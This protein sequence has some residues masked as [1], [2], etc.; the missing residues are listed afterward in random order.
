[1]SN[2]PHIFNRTRVRAHRDRAAARFAEYD[3]LFRE[4]TLR[5]DERLD[6]FNKSFPVAL[7]LGAH[8]GLLGEMLSDRKTET[9]IYAD[10]SERMLHQAGSGVVCDEEL[11][12]FADNS[13]DLVISACSLHWVN[14]LPG[15]FIQIRKALKPG[16]LFLAILPGGE[17]LKELRQS[18]EQAEIGLTSGVSPRVSPFVDARDAAG[19]LQ[20]AGFQ[21]PVADSDVIDVEYEHPLKLMEDLRGMGEC[22]A[23]EASRKNFT[24]RKLIQRACEQYATHFKAGDGRVKASFELV[25][26]TGIKS[27]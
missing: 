3:F 27:P 7:D 22:N 19:L 10:L 1:M 18:L 8:N 16:G 20:R 21:M 4:M 2:N 25:T 15:T 13:F 11:L 26:L 14:D 6:D 23:I 9:I 17:T 24:S 12:P 5:L